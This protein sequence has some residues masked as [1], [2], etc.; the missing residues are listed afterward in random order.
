MFDVGFLKP[1][2]FGDT[3]FYIRERMSQNCYAVLTK[4]Q[5]FNIY[6]TGS[7]ARETHIRA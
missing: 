5:Y 4:L 1:H 6:L 2:G 7:L 3:C